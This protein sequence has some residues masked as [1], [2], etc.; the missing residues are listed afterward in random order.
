MLKW[1]LS[2]R[3]NIALMINLVLLFSCMFGYQAHAELST[4]ESKTTSP[5]N[6]YSDVE[7]LKQSVLELNR[8]LLILEE[9]LLFPASTQVSIFLSM[10]IGEFFQ[11]DAVKLKLNDKLVASH[12]YTD[13]QVDAL[14][15]GGVQRLYMG[16]LKAGSHEV[17]AFFTGKG[18][19]GREYKRGAK[20][21]LEK[22]ASSKMLELRIVDSTAKLQPIFDIKEWQL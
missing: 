8:D 21:M 16:N 14:Y 22:D 4:S 12:L 19:Q 2:D 3:N 11:L 5:S 7:D 1:A 6:L 18:P 15:R 10:D 20:L 9:E 13:H 17:S